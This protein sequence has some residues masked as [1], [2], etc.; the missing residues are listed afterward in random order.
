MTEPRAGVD[1]GWNH[2]VHHHPRLCRL[3]AGLPAPVLDVG[4]GD[5]GLVAALR[6]SG[7][8]AW[9]CDPDPVAVAA[10]VPGARGRLFRGSA[11]AL[12]VPDSSCG[13]VVLGAVLHHV[14]AALALA[15]ARRAVV[16]GGRV[17]VLSVARTGGW[18]DLPA[19]AADVLAHQVLSRTRGRWHEPPTARAEPTRTWAEEAALLQR[20]L[21][22]ARTRRVR[23][24]RS[25]T[26]WDAPA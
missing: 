16:P 25:V 19:E 22:G 15:E 26:V 13:G 21:P 18:R 3:L 8:P 14:D 7:T 9:G 12:P 5:G 17:V 2:N 4:C 10:A 23:L 20:H 1:V 6:A 11:E 24:W